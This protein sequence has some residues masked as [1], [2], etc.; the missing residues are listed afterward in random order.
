LHQAREQFCLERMQLLVTEGLWEDAIEYLNSLLPACPRSFGAQVFHNF[1]LMHHQIARLVAGHKDAL[2]MIETD[3]WMHY[4]TYADQSADQLVPRVMAR[5]VLFL[6]NV[7]KCMNWGQVRSYAAD[8][9]DRLA[10]QTPELNGRLTL[11]AR[12][13]M[14]QNVLPV[15]LGLPRRFRMKKQAP[16]AKPA[17][18]ARVIRRSRRYIRRLRQ[19]SFESFDEAKEWLC[20]IIDSSLQGGLH[21]GCYLVKHSGNEGDPTLPIW[22]VTSCA[23]SSGVTATQNAGTEKKQEGC[24]T[25]MGSAILGTRKNP[26]TEHAIIE[27]FLGTKKQRTTGAFG[28][29][30]LGPLSVAGVE[31]HSFAAHPRM[32]KNH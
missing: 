16:R 20:T 2:Y 27:D 18:V 25:E 22:E 6:D 26:R 10:W 19:P 30:S 13:M 21:R 8:Y 32:I 3:K 1:L 11:P 17:I 23:G 12:G 14:P 4:V 7:R 28:E 24:C 29:S 15:G 31:G 5:S 9:L